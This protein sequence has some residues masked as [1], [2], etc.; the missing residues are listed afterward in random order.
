GR[1]RREY[2]LGRAVGTVA[3]AMLQIGRDWQR[4]GG[5]DLAAMVYPLLERNPTIGQAAGEGVAGAG[6]CQCLE[7]QRGEQLRRADIPGVGNDEGAFSLVKC[8][9][10]GT[11]VSHVPSPDFLFTHDEAP[12]A[13]RCQGE[14]LVRRWAGEGLRPFRWS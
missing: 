12:A 5:N 1:L 7:T 6:R 4:C 11:D 3:L 8:A 9:K 14:A 10:D 13:W 2:C